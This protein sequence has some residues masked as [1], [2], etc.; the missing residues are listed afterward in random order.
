MP[1]GS[2]LL[3]EQ[4]GE[5]CSLCGSSPPV[6]LVQDGLCAGWR[7]LLDQHADETSA[8]WVLS[9]ANNLISQLDEPAVA[10]ALLEHDFA[11][12]VSVESLVRSLNEVA[13]WCW[14]EPAS[15]NTSKPASDT[16]SEIAS[17]IGSEPTS[18]PQCWLICNWIR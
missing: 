18:Q 7:A 10:D 15:E 12:L 14:S 3:V 11:S 16:A 8:V 1:T 17:D 2:A 13:R 4:L 6:R 9:G 5:L